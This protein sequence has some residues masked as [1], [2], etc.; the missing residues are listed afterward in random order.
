MMGSVIWGLWAYL[1]MGGVVAAWVAT[2]V[3]STIISVLIWPY[4]VLHPPWIERKNRR[5]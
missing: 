4:Y 5:G 2:D 3:R 1:V